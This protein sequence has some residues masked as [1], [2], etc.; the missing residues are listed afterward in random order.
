MLS[1]SLWI[2]LKMRLIYWGSIWLVKNKEQTLMNQNRGIVG[3]KIDTKSVVTPCSVGVLGTLLVCIILGIHW[4]GWVF[5]KGWIK[6]SPWFWKM[7]SSYSSE[8]ENHGNCCE[9]IWKYTSHYHLQ[10]RVCWSHQLPGLV[11]NCWASGYG[12]TKH[13]PIIRVSRKK[14]GTKRIEICGLRMRG[15][16]ES[17]LSVS[18][19]ISIKESGWVWPWTRL[20]CCPVLVATTHTKHLNCGLSKLKCVIQRK[21]T[22]KFQT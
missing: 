1:V 13:L 10:G 22:L 2:T 21:Y 11:E 18:Q 17:W 16:R 12:Q 9:D 5:K 8:K 3:I 19:E 4:L 20:L 6:K 7:P 14:S 15:G